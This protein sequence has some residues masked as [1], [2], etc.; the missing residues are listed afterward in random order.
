MNKWQE[1]VKRISKMNPGKSLKMILPLARVEYKKMGHSS[2]KKGKKLCKPSRARRSTRGVRKPRRGRRGR[3]RK[4]SGKMKGGEAT[5]NSMAEMHDVRLANDDSNANVNAEMVGGRHC[6]TKHRK[7]KPKRRRASG[8]MKGG[9]LGG[10][11]NNGLPGQAGLFG[12]QDQISQND[13]GSSDEVLTHRYCG[14][15]GCG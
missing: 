11:W 1:T 9:D 7:K 15:S 14:D 13:F 10:A 4:A 6:N 8:K 2:T 12:F 5:E 3:G